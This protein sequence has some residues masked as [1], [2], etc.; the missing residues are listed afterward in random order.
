[1]TKMSVYSL[2]AAASAAALT[3]VASAQAPASA[4]AWDVRWVVD[5]TGPFAQGPTASAVGITLYARVGIL[6]NGSASGTTNLGV[7]RVG[8]STVGS[9]TSATGF[10]VAFNDAFS[11]GL[12]ASQ[13]TVGAGNTRDVDGLSLTDTN[14]SLLAGHFRQFRGA[15]APQVTP[16][17]LGS[18]TDVNNGVF[19]NPSTGAPELRNLVGARSLN[20]FGATQGGPAGVATLRPD[21]TLNP[22]TFFQEAVPVYRLY[23]IP[24]ADGN[25]L[26]RTI[27]VNVSGLSVRYVF[28][29]NGTDGLTTAGPT[30]GNSS[31]SFVVPTPGAAAL[32]GL[33]ALAAARRRRA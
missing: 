16:Q 27:T 10:R 6:N 3:S 26:G 21:Q 30:L 17:F 12:G 4:Q 8:G 15:F 7:S 11:A 2:L 24:R 14:G 1:M 33:G 18:N 29:Q 31:F 19:F 20:G 23:Y 13:G 25:G 9:G 28:G 5:S 22:N 32:M